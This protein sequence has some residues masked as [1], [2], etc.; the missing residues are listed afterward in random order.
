MQMLDIFGVR[1]EQILLKEE[2]QKS[3]VAALI[4]RIIW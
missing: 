1:H 4:Y 2:R 3:Q